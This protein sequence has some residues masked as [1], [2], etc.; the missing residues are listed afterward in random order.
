MA[1][2]TSPDIA[3]QFATATIFPIVCDC[4]LKHSIYCLNIRPHI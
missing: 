1:D 2:R 3:H 4:W